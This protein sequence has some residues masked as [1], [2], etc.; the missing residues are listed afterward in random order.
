[1]P[2][3]PVTHRLAACA[4][5]VVTRLGLRDE[6]FTF[7]LS[8]GVLEAVPRLSVGVGEH[9]R[10]IAPNSRVARLER[11]PALGAVALAS[12]AARGRIHLPTYKVQ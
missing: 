9:L 7:V 10:A 4:D 12:A 5:S 6:A 3:S 2:A 11:E 8:G 1:M